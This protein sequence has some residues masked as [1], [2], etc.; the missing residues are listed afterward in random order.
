M[1]AV[2]ALITVVIAL[3]AGSDYAQQEMR[4]P[5]YAS[6]VELKNGFVICGQEYTSYQESSAGY[7]CTGGRYSSY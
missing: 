1:Y 3:S 7:V 6:Y 4:I 5:G 2:K